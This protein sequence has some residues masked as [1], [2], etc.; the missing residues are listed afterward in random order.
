MHTAKSVY[1]VSIRLTSERWE[2]ISQNHPECAGYLYDVLGAVQ[3][4]ER[5]FCGKSGEYIAVKEIP[6]TDKFLI[7]VYREIDNND[8]FIITAFITKRYNWLENRR[9]IWP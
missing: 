9:Q 6:E 7:V 1:N 2:H 8:G 5:I 4:P 3:K